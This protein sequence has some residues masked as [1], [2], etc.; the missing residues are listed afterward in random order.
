MITAT[1]KAPEDTR[2]LGAQVAQLAQPGD[3]LLLAGDLGAGKTTFTQGFGRALGIAERITSPTFTLVRSYEGERLRLHHADLYR[4]D[5]G[6]EILDLGLPELVDD[7]AV[8]LVEWGERAAPAVGPD[9]L[10]LRLEFGEA[11]DDRRLVFRAVGSS[12]SGRLARLA[13]AVGRFT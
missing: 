7:D 11:D 12:W 5:D 8:L 6:S 13:D 4:I 10:D 3:V 1:T 2:E 9:F